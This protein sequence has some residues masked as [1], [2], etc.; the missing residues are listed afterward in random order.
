MWERRQSYCL[1]K[2][3]KERMKKA[4]EQQQR[5]QSITRRESIYQRERRKSDGKSLSGI[6]RIC[7]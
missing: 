5:R 7:L 1:E 3:D 6:Y 4:L 2:M